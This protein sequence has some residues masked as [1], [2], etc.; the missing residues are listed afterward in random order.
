MI[1]Y[2]HFEITDSVGVNSSAHMAARHLLSVRKQLKAVQ[3]TVPG[4][5][6]RC[7]TRQA[8]DRHKIGAVVTQKANLNQSQKAAGSHQARAH[9]HGHGQ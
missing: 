3:K 7:G 6:L 2:S 1:E 5:H 8:Q 4:R 9:V